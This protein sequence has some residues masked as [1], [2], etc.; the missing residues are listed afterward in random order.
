MRFLPGFQWTDIQ[1]PFLWFFNEW[2]VYFQLILVC[3]VPGSI[4]SAGPNG[5]L[6]GQGLALPRSPA[7]LTTPPVVLTK[8]SMARSPS[9]SSRGAS[10]RG[11][12]YHRHD[13][14]ASMREFVPNF[15][16][17]QAA[18]VVATI[19]GHDDRVARLVWGQHPQCSVEI[20]PERSPVF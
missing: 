17:G 1:L 16:F 12:H 5:R 7:N 10:K 15:R 9:L 14:H 18:Q 11:R 3:E 20:V 19:R 6:L 4:G 8:S 13:R 2:S